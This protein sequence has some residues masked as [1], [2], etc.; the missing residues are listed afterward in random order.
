MDNNEQAHNLLNERFD[1]AKDVL[2]EALDY[3]KENSDH[4]DMSLC[5][6]GS[7]ELGQR[8]YQYLKNQDIHIDF[9]CDSEPKQWDTYIIDGKKCFSISHLA[10]MRDVVT[11]IIAEEDSTAI[12]EQLLE[13]SIVAVIPLFP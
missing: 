4:P 2:L 9:F 7:G 10:G 8:V 11:V 3:L 5:L 1:A 6:F 12:E 13:I